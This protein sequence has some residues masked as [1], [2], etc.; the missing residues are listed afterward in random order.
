MWRW[1]NDPRICQW[2]DTA[3]C[4][5]AQWSP[6]LGYAEYDVYWNEEKY[7]CTL[8][9]S[10]GEAFLGNRGLLGT[11]YTDTGEPFLFS[12]W[13][14]SSGTPTLTA[15]QKSTAD[16]ETVHVKVTTHAYTRYSQLPVEYMTQALPHYIDVS[17][18]L[19]DD[20]G[21]DTFVCHE[22]VARVEPLIQSG[23]LVRMRIALSVGGN[24]QGTLVCDLNLYGDLG[25]G[26]SMIFA[27]TTPLLKS[28]MFIAIPDGQGGYM[29][30]YAT[31]YGIV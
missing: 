25:A 27:E 9:T 21:S 14:L 8:Q 4:T 6:D 26:L 11:S 23:R 13:A 5:G 18:D 17:L 31:N 28:N 24:Y 19:S 2:T 1:Q 15:I 20:G 29:V 30:D 7:V 12:G 16:V 3:S 22:K 10:D